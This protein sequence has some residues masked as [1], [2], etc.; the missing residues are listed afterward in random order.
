VSMTGLSGELIPLGSKIR[1]HPHSCTMGTASFPRVQRPERGID[2]PPPSSDGLRMVWY[3]SNT[4][5]SRLCQHRRVTGCGD[6]VV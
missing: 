6:L 2:H 1:C 3:S 4:F 5:A